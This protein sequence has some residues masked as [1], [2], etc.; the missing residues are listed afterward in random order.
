MCI[1]NLL[2][3]MSVHVILKLCYTI[4]SYYK[5]NCLAFY[6]SFDCLAIF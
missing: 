6:S 2:V 3:F 4:T 1:Q 5:Q